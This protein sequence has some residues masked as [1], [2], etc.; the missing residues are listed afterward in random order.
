MIKIT[1]LVFLLPFI[2]VGQIQ[3]IDSLQS[4]LVH[5][6]GK[7]KIKVLLDLCWEYRFTN[8]DTARNYGLTAL[9]LARQAGSRDYE[10]EAL[11]NIGV[12]HEAQGNYSEALTYELQAL[13]LRRKIGDD[14]KTANTLNNLGIIYDEQGNYQK[15]LE[16]YFEARKIYEHLGDPSKTAMVLVNIGI[17]LR[18]QKEF[19]QVLDYYYQAIS[20][21]KRLENS[22]ALAACHANLGSVYLNMSMYDS[23]LHYSLL[24]TR[25]FERQNIQQFLPT[26]LA[27][28][29]IAYDS[30]GENQLAKEYLLRAKELHEKY[31]NK[32]ELSTV[33][34]G[35]SHIYAKMNQI[36]LAEA[37]AEQALIIAEKIGAL[38]QQMH[39]HLNL[40]RI[41][42]LRKDFEGAYRE[43]LKY[44]VAKD[45]LF[46]QEKSKQM[47]EFQTKYETEKKEQE[48][49]MQKL[50]ITEQKLTLQ[51]NKA[52][53]IGLV[54]LL[55]LLALLS[56]LIRSQIKLKQQKQI[57]E[58]QRK[59]QEELTHAVIELQERER[60]RFAQD[61]HD[62]FGQMI[63]ALKFQLENSDEETENAAQLIGQMQDEIRNVSF[64]L[65]PQVL[66][67]DGLMHALQELAS[68][69]NKSGNIHLIVLSTGLEKRLTANSE[70]TIYRICQ[71]WLNNVLKYSN[72]KKIILQLVNHPDELLLTIEDDGAGFDSSLLEAGNGNGWKNIQSRARIL[73]GEV[74]I[75]TQMN[76]AGTTFTLHIPTDSNIYVA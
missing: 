73:Q 37:S 69:F 27:N 25:E 9:R 12:T 56:I 62:G 43:Q 15:A 40:G 66:V 44:S 60:S 10:V 39:A 46:Q 31:N 55:L 72:S 34:I 53:I 64:A 54:I 48:I 71:E 33:L 57:E 28:A 47:A 38:E 70:I 42:V 16:Y 29:G 26:T 76:V 3:N 11:H 30:I 13:D 51:R 75:D 24:A 68:R 8:A 35:L 21:Y 63:T 49:S 4:A 17:V 1:C 59:H 18:A 45:S 65:S 74:D 2:T 67:R 50:V 5:A 36:A 19:K 22:F 32:K 52:F 6:E 7:D 14:L 20:I 23:S 41:K 58:Q 61:L